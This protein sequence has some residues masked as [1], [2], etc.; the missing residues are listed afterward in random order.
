MNWFGHLLLGWRA[1]KD[2]AFAL[3]AALPDLARVARCPRV[4]AL[5]PSRLA[6]GVAHHHD[7]DAA[8][9]GGSAFTSL[10]AE[11]TARLEAVGIRRGVARAAAHVGIELHLDGMLAKQEDAAAALAAGLGHGTGPRFTTALGWSPEHRESWGKLMDR[12]TTSDVLSAWSDPDEVGRRVVRVLSRRPRLA[13]ES[14][15]T[16]AMETTIAALW[17]AVEERHAALVPSP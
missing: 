10:L 5:S 12:L 2:A 9:H 14:R 3:G 4:R 16:E 15:E 7:I 8:F 17:V 1:E 6:D 11:G 13:P